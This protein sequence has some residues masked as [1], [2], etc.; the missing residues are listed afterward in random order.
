MADQDAPTVLAGAKKS[1]EAIVMRALIT[2]VLVLLG[3]VGTMVGIPAFDSRGSTGTFDSAILREQIRNDV[4]KEVSIAIA[5]EREASR[6]ALQLHEVV[7]H[8]RRPSSQYIE[9]TPQ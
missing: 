4:A 3:A 7:G 5:R 9:K 6:H 1:G 2:S 8:T